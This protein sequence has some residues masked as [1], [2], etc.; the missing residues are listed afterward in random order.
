[1]DYSDAIKR[2]GR[3]LGYLELDPTNT[4]LLVETAELAWQTGRGVEAL[5][6]L[7]KALVKNPTEAKL[8][9]AK[10]NTLLALNRPGEAAFIF[11][12]LIQ[13][14]GADPVLSFNL[15]QARLFEG[16]TLESLSLLDAIPE[17]G[18]AGLPNFDVVYSRTAYQ[19]GR[20]PEAISAID[21]FLAANPGHP[22]AFGLRTLLLFDAGQESEAVGLAR[23]LLES[24]ADEWTAHLVVGYAALEA[25]DASAAEAHFTNVV[26][27]IPDAG[28]AWSG[29]GFAALLRRDLAAARTRLEKAV[30]QMTDHPGTWQGLAW[31]C[32]LLG[33]VGAARA[34]IDRSLQVDRN[35]ADNHGTLAVIEFLQGKKTEAELSIRKA[36]RLNPLAPSALYAR[37][38]LLESSGNRAAASAIVE[39]I[40]SSVQGPQGPALMKMYR[41]SIQV[42][43]VGTP[44]PPG[45]RLH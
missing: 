22:E 21:R 45:T 1:M 18:R 38:L 41:S 23:R 31:T 4:A 9:S 17:S 37:S 26:E 36:L 15:S 24:G 10:G 14:H 29:L 28:R 16:R 3:L 32:I 40:L 43:G 34:A 2:L 27:R 12:T 20:I 13:Q 33:D 30:G 11:Q 42:G 7:D 5:E 39:K 35:F 25:Q 19:A 6:L 8:L 44:R